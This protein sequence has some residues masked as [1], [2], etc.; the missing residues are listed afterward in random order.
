MVKGKVR[1]PH[2]VCV[3][4]DCGAM[5]MLERKGLSHVPSAFCLKEVFQVSHSQLCLLFM[6]CTAA[7]SCVQSLLAKC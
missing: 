6:L 5:Q 3:S 1:T 7:A 4:P 2:A